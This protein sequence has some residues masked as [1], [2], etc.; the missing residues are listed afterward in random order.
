MD[1][2]CPLI[3]FE[4]SHL[5][6]ETGPHQPSRRRTGRALR[7]VTTKGTQ[8]TVVFNGVKTVDVQDSKHAQANIGI[9]YAP[10]A[11][12]IPG[13]AIKCREVEVREV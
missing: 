10:G 8:L 4:C 9:Q 13:G 1:R 12:N 11:N 3:V 2:L 7:P 6:R 5:R